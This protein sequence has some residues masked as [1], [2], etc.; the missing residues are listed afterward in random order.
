M[1]LQ[2]TPATNKMKCPHC[3]SDQWKFNG[4]KITGGK[5]GNVFAAQFGV[6]SGSSG[7]QAELKCLSCNKKFLYAPQAAQP[8]EMLSA[9]AIIAYCVKKNPMQKK[10]ARH[11][12]WINGVRA[13]A[14]VAM[15]DLLELVVQTRYNT[16]FLTS[17]D[18]AT[19]WNSYRFEVRPGERVE[20]TTKMGIPRNNLVEVSRSGGM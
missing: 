18:I 3:G 2:M 5:I 4:E 11:Y 19:N 13:A 10:Q 17:P 6:Q 7:A 20:I 1:Q 14:P 8:D 9:P 12:L 15:G 16:M